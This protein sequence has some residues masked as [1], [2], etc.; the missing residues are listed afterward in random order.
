MA[1]KHKDRDGASAAMARKRSRKRSAA[2]PLWLLASAAAA[3]GLALVLSGVLGG[4]ATALPGEDLLDGDHRLAKLKPLRTRIDALVSGAADEAA[5][6]PD[7][8]AA[9]PSRRFSGR[10]IVTAGGGRG[11]FSQLYV[12]LKVIRVHHESTLPV[13]VFYAGDD[14]LPRQASCG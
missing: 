8:P 10:G 1:R 7:A 3:V 5:R 14:E 12:W 13:E 11:L 9:Y 4:G 2:M 6:P